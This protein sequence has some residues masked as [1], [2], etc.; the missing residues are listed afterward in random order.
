LSSINRSAFDYG[1]NI[2]SNTL[3]DRFSEL[4]WKLH[5]TTG[6]QVAVLIDE[7]DKPI[8]ENLS[9]PSVVA[10]N[11]NILHGFYQVLKATD[12]HLRFIFLTGVSKFAGVSIF[13][14][15][16]NL[17]DITLD[18]NYASICGY[19]QTEMEDYFAEY[20]DVLSERFTLSHEDVLR[21][22]RTWYSGYSWNGKTPVYNP[23]STLLLFTEEQFD[24]YWFRTGTPTLLIELLKKRN[25][26][27]PILE[28]VIV[29]SS[30]FE[31][32]NPANIS[33]TSLLF[34][35]GYLTIKQRKF[36]KGQP[37]Y[38]L[39]IPNREVSE[40]LLKCLPSFVPHNS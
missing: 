2:E 20:I 23:F 11:K 14:G 7:Y 13:S 19:T 38:T 22:I 12:E 28:P 15:L 8:T 34:Q 21:E 35:I 30:V 29:D 39:G 33:E 31:S 16:N 18:D 25:Q 6:R 26:L 36:I 32:F 3:N 4:I 27:Q 1:V 17:N 10:E 5:Q 9:E 40:S 37:E 24:N